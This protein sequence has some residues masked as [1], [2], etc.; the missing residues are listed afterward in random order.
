MERT[1]AIIKPDGIKRKLVGEILKRYEQKNLN[2]IELK[3]IM[4]TKEILE[5]HYG[6]HKGKPFYNELISYMNDYVIVIILEGEN[7]ISMVRKINGATNPRD[8]EPGTIRGD[9][10]LS[11][12]ENL[13]HGSDSKESAD[14]EINIW[15]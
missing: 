1:L 9:F 12:T 10:S 14:R 11:A 3:M 5:K 2:I 4:A 8:S 13:V 15:F 7:A 6:E